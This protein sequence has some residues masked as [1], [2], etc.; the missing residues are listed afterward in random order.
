MNR[1][2]LL[3]DLITFNKPISVLDEGLSKLGWDYDGKPLLVTAKQIQEI[4]KR[5]LAGEFSAQ[6]LE[7]W[8]NLVECREDLEFEEKKQDE[9]ANV[10]HCLANPVL[11]GSI[12]DD[13]CKVLIGT[14]DYQHD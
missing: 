3:R 10:I 1:F 6:E 9:I 5:F 12:T 8:A 4:L 7:D 11:E 13:S 14:L 2:D